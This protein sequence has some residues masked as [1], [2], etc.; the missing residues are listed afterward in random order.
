MLFGD[1]I[2]DNNPGKISTL[3]VPN[4]FNS[5]NRFKYDYLHRSFLKLESEIVVAGLRIGTENLF[6][7]R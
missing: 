2:R 4:L 1:S 6:V 3:L 7:S 5:L